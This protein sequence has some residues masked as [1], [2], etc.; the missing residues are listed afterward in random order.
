M[1]EWFPL[2]SRQSLRQSCFAGSV[3]WGQ[4]LFFVRE[5]A[6]SS[7]SGKLG[8]G[9]GS[10][11][12][13]ALIWSMAATKAQSLGRREITCGSRCCATLRSVRPHR[14]CWMRRGTRSPP[15]SRRS[16]PT[17][18]KLRYGSVARDRAWLPR[19]QPAK[20]HARLSFCDMV[21]CQAAATRPAAPKSP[22]PFD[23]LSRHVAAA[24]AADPFSAATDP[25]SAAA[26]TRSPAA[27]SPGSKPGAPWDADSHATDDAEPVV[28]SFVPWNTRKTQI[29]QV[30]RSRGPRSAA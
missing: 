29:M 30:S 3:L 11:S 15:R 7:H 25:L 14:R 1:D 28:T 16:R 4:W 23:P 8:H 12:P 10:C 22:E 13:V 21:V 26:A 2:P 6:S 19:R 24:A 5:R 20:M 9:D 18:S 27:A 17:R